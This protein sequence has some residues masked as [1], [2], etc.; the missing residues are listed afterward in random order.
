MIRLRNVLLWGVGLLWISGCADDSPTSNDGTI[1]P[2]DAVTLEVRLPFSQFA[3]DFRR[4]EGFGTP[5]S[6]PKTYVAHDWGGGVEA[7][8]MVQFG[9]LPRIIFVRPPGSPATVPDST[10]VPVSGELI[11][12]F[13]T[14][15]YQGSGTFELEAAAIE[16]PWHGPSADWFLSVDTV[17]ATSAWPE[18]G[19]GPVRVLDQAEWDPEEVIA[20]EDPEDD[21]IRVDFVTLEVD[22]TT[23][24][25]WA[26]PE[27]AG[28]GLR[29]SSL[30]PES[31]LAIRSVELNVRVRPSVNPD[32]LVSV[33]VGL[34][35]VT[36]LA[37]P[38]PG[39][40]TETFVIG[41][42]PAHRATFRLDLP[43]TIEGTP[44]ACAIVEC[45]LALSPD[46]LVYA[47]LELRTT[48]PDPIGLRPL[49]PIV[50][51]IRPVLDPGR[52]PRSPLGFPL[53][54][55][56]GQCPMVLPS[57]EVVEEDFTV[58]A[59]ARIDLPM[60]RYVRDL[61]RDPADLQA[62]I[63]STVTLLNGLDA[64]TGLELRPLQYA[65]FWGPGTELEPILRLVLTVSTGVPNP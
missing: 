47:G 15:D 58:G 64:A 7:R 11:L 3:T 29:I 17:G 65:S 8:A 20:P 34:A 25:E 6:L 9:A 45:P 41:G 52:L 30:T 13:D 43:A 19:G 53:A 48:P 33:P 56:S 49:E 55:P 42:A 23:V 51:E 46:R 12:R 28:R 32:T 39:A 2:V 62:E 18:P 63:P 27:F 14:L 10:Y 24:T 60:T 31:R 36:Y 22:S 1:L 61:L 5:A 50:I 38:T 26:D 4:F 16:T 59:P 44:E 35:Q 54:C 40:L 21:P 37:D 57:T